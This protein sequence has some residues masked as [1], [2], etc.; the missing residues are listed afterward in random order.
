MFRNQTR[1]RDEIVFMDITDRGH[2]P[3]DAQHY[4]RAAR[5]AR[6]IVERE[7]GTV[8]MSRF[9]FP[10]VPSLQT[11][12][13]NIYFESYGCFADL[14]GSGHATQ[15]QELTQQLLARARAAA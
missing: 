2:I 1:L 14:D 9:I 4:Q 6:E 13:E 12:A 10:D 3:I 8:K 15:A 5:I 7:L 11:T